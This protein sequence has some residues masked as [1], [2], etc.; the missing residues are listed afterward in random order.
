M[1][2]GEIWGKE[3]CQLVEMNLSPSPQVFVLSFL[4]KGKAW[5]V[6]RIKHE[7]CLFFTIIL[8]LS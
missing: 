1:K 6:G 5:K 7:I 8:N 4:E 3:S 2:G